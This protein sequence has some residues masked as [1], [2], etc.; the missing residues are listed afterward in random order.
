MKM[1]C[2][3]PEAPKGG[4]LARVATPVGQSCAYCAEP[5]AAD[6]WGFLVPLIAEHEATIE[7]WHRECFLRQITGS[8]SHVLKVCGCYVP[9]ATETDPPELSLR[10]AAKLAVEEWEKVEKG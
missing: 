2:F 3:G 9:G 6:D 7:P 8:V 5:I 4:V 10:E 1:V